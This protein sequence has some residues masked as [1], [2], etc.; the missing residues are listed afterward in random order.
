M[1]LN[2][3]RYFKDLRIG[4]SQGAL[5]SGSFKNNVTTCSFFHGLSTYCDRF[6]KEKQSSI[7]NALVA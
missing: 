3:P 7:F 4:G 1:K 2:H 5:P 6:T